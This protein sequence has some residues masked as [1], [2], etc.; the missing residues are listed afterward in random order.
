MVQGISQKKSKAHCVVKDETI[1][2]LEEVV[3]L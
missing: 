1:V 3:I 2:K